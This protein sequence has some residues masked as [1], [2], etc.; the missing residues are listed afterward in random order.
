[1]RARLTL[2]LYA[3]T[4]ADSFKALFHPYFTALPNPTHPSKL[5]KCAA[6]LAALRSLDNDVE[7]NSTGLGVKAAPQKGLKRKMSSVSSDPNKRV[8]SRKL[9]FSKSVPRSPEMQ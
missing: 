7:K 3:Q 4:F 8:I 9:D 1:M 2:T 6:T 5:P